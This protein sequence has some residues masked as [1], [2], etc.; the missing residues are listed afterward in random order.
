MISLF[1]Y[2]LL[3]KKDAEEGNEKNRPSF[4]PPPSEGAIVVAEG[5]FS[6]FTFDLSGTNNSEA[7][8]I[9]RY[10]EAAEYPD[11]DYAIDDI[12]NEAISID[13]DGEVVR[14]NMENFDE[15]SVF[16]QKDIQ[17]KVNKSFDRIIEL[18]DFNNSAH[19]IF[20]QWYI[21]GRIYYHLIVDQTR[22]K[23]GI[24]ELRYIDPRKIRKVKEV[25]KVADQKSGA[26]SYQIKG[27]YYVYSSVGFGQQPIGS[28][29]GSGT[30]GLDNTIYGLKIAKDSIAYCHSGLFDKTGNMV[31]SN[32]HKALRILNSLKSLEDSMVIYRLVRA[33]ERR[34]FYIDVGN[35]PKQ[36]AEQYLRDMMVK[37]KNKLIFDPA[38]GAVKDDRRFMTMHEDYWLPRREGGKGTQIDVLPGAQNLGNIEDVEYFKKDLY[39][40]LNVPLS[41]MNPETSGFTFSKAAE[42]SRDE[43]KFS[44]FVDRLRR[45]FSLIL[46]ELLTKHMVLTGVISV[47]DIPDF[48]SG[49][50]FEF[51]SDN[52]FAEVKDN[53]ILSRRI[54]VA[55]D[56]Q[57]FVGKYFSHD[58]VRRHVFRQDDEEIEKMDSEIQDEENDPRY[59]TKPDGSN[60]IDVFDPTANGNGGG[61]PGMPG[62]PG[63]PGMM[64]GMPGQVDP[65]TGMPVQQQQ[66][67]PQQINSHKEPG[68]EE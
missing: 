54:E 12:V 52:H 2:E 16:A 47:E 68:D 60:G 14:I 65:N 41:R 17:D 49:A 66:Q 34:V 40:A 5:N 20:R 51:Q 45:Q 61:F 22:L 21:D 58:Y 3:K 31:I 48:M 64:P 7:D 10:R 42:I 39:R 6:G 38:T 25:K 62:Q 23:E 57:D 59:E 8:L 33:P 67:R 32:L 35:L 29:G 30:I 26:T 11:V 1:G 28:A 4:V 56:L 43:V 27:E 9:T 46:F 55:K 50:F 36:K 13:E 24:K 15:N 53:E 44:R 19:R 18:L 37:H 63:M